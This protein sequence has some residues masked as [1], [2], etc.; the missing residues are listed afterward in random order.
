MNDGHMHGG[1][2]MAPS[3]MNSTGTM[4]HPHHRMMMMH[5]TFFW[6][7]NSEILFSGWPG[8][9]SAMY[10]LALVFVF[11]LAFIVE[12]LSHSRFIKQEANHVAAGLAQ[13][14]MH[15]LRVGLAYLVMLAVMSFNAGV[16]IVAV[17]GHTLGFF[18][19]GSRVFKKSPESVSPLSD[20]ME[21][22]HDM[23]GMMPPSPM[24]GAGSNSTHHHTM[25]TMH[26]TFFWGKNAEILF[27]GWPGKRTGM[28]ILALIFVFV[29][30][31]LM[32]WLSHCRLIKG[33][34]LKVT[35]TTRSL[36]TIVH[37]IRMA[38]SYMVMLAVMSF[39]VGVFLVAVAGHGLGFLIF[40]SRVD[41]TSN[42]PAGSC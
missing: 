6:G 13:T 3:T 37:A 33:S 12:W 23:G 38:L 29:L 16:F 26:M 31:F 10:A 8:T 1:M 25:M 41:D 28:Y 22:K 35:T 15:A 17:A 24:D 7:K 39:N 40:G 36:R 27:A 11:F 2:G 34:A 19:F 9:N 21:G 4:V 32:E 14:L 20:T 42:L 30:S 18:F 5:M